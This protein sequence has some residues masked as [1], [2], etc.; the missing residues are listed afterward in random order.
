MYLTT[1]VLQTQ[2]HHEVDLK[3]LYAMCYH[4]ARLYN[5][6]LYSV[7]QHYFS[8]QTY[9][10]YNKNY[11]ECSGNENY[12][13]LLS[14][15]AQQILRLVDRDMQ[16]FFRLLVL[17]KSGKYSDKL[18]LPHYKP[19][20]G[21]AVCPI[22]GRSCR[23]Q[24]D[25]TIA[26]GLTKEFRELYGFTERRFFLRMP[27]HLKGVKEFK[28]IRIIP[29]YNGKQFS[30][31]FVYEQPN[32]VQQVTG[33]GYMSIDLGVTNFAAC[34]CFSGNGARQ[35]LIDGRALKSINHYYNKQVS[36]LK[37]EYSKNKSI[38]STNTK[39]MLRLMN[40]RTNR[41][42]DYFNKTVKLL[43]NT[44]LEQGLSTLVIGYNKEQKEGV[45]IGKVN[46]QN[47]VFTPHHKFREKLKY[48]CE[49][50]GIKYCPQEESYTS[51]SSCLDLDEIPNYG[52]SEIPAFSGK[53]V[54]RG[55]Y[56]SSE[57][58]VLN[59]DINGSVN[60]LRKYF[61]ERKENWYYQDSV[62]VLVNAPCKRLNAFSEAHEF[63]RG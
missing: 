53:R 3:V 8:T 21:L 38:T 23:I 46:N 14:D 37:P 44:C 20:D 32:T 18:R 31:E 7:R 40:G 59:A 6:G 60:I 19:S 2:K 16:S 13:L 26:I 55:L 35:F 10:P 41:I 24:K 1:K 49:L 30:V 29:Q 45:N 12:H 33:D 15:S 22:Q 63:I 50:H 57:G 56:R 17:A 42:T 48:Q 43:I 51:K 54:H 61:K 36:M 39:R 4:A 25:G 62:R 47:L 58:F 5:V 52:D 27:K 9:L 28:E 11:K 34:T